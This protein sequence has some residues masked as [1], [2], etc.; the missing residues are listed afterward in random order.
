MDDFAEASALIGHLI[1]V[2]L[3]GA[4]VDNGTL[5]AETVADD[6]VGT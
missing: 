1:S 5:Q 3:I 4:L 2:G 6:P